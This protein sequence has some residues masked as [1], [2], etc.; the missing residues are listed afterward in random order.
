MKKLYLKIGFILFSEPCTEYESV[1]LCTQIAT[2]SRTDNCS[3]KLMNV[4]FR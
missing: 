1:Y 3:L 2:C 4:L